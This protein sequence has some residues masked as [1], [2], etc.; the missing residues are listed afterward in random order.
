MLDENHANWAIDMAFT[1]LNHSS[2]KTDICSEVFKAK[3]C[4]KLATA[5]Y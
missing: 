5:L 1:F 4:L 2:M 3:I